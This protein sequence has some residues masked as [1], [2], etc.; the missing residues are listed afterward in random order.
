[1]DLSKKHARSPSPWPTL[2]KSQ[3][4]EQIEEELAMTYGIELKHS[5]GAIVVLLRGCALD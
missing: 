5:A 2:K 3:E 1:M 4:Q